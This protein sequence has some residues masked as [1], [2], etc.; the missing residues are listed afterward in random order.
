MRRQAIPTWCRPLFG[1]AMACGLAVAIVVLAFKVDAA[2][3][4][5]ERANAARV[6]AQRYWREAGLDKLPVSYDRARFEKAVGGE[7]DPYN[8][9][10]AIAVATLTSNPE[11]KESVLRYLNEA[12]L[13]YARTH[14]EQYL[15]LVSEVFYN[16]STDTD[17]LQG[18]SKGKYTSEGLAVAFINYA[19]FLIKTDRE[20]E[21]LGLVLPGNNGIPEAV[22]SF[23]KTLNEDGGAMIPDGA[24]RLG[25]AR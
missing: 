4:D 3:I 1:P 22:A 17:E 10:G 12:L 2:D 6:L 18:L 15:C 25:C 16:S 11:R 23:K 8:I 13:P 21:K 9:V 20:R 7:D 14:K 5:R 19:Y 24:V